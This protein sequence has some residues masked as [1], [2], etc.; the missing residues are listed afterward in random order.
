MI[1]YVVTGSKGIDSPPKPHQYERSRPPVVVG[2]PQYSIAG[3]G[4]LPCL[5]RPREPS[6]FKRKMT[7]QV[8]SL[9]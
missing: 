4:T 1:Y 8:V 5:C 3:L 6:R 2:S 9:T 7:E